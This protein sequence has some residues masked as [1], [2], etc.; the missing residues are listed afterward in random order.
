M[1]CLLILA[2]KQAFADVFSKC[3]IFELEG[4]LMR[5]REAILFVINRKSHSEIAVTVPKTLK[6]DLRIPQ[7]VRVRL[8]I[9]EPCEYGCASAKLE[10]IESL[11]PFHKPANPFFPRIEPKTEETC[12]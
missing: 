8:R 12:P 10:V 4:H 11:D 3:G 7:P 6:M 1:S 2:P 9:T 5:D